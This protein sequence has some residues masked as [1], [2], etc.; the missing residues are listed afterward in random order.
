MLPWVLPSFRTGAPLWSSC[1]WSGAGREWVGVGGAPAAKTTGK[2]ETAACSPG[3]ARQTGRA[4]R[5]MLRDS[6]NICCVEQSILNSSVCSRGGL[7]LWSPLPGFKVLCQSLHRAGLITLR[8]WGDG[9]QGSPFLQEETTGTACG[10]QSLSTTWAL[11]S[12]SEL[13]QLVFTRNK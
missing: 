6:C 11:T 1:R 12:S 10:M 2:E 13:R 3:W 5:R 7:L 4:R 8:S 9:V